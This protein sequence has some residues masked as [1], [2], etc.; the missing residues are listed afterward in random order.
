MYESKKENALKTLEKK[1]TKVDEINKVR[2]PPLHPTLSSSLVGPR[3]PRAQR[4]TGLSTSPESSTAPRGRHPSRAREAPQ[5]ARRVHEVDGGQRQAGAPEALLPRLRVQPQRRRARRGRGRYR[6]AAPAGAGNPS[7]PPRSP[8]PPQHCRFSSPNA[9]LFSRRAL[10]PS[11][12]APIS[13]QIKQL[14]KDVIELDSELRRVQSE[15]EEVRAEAEAQSGGVHRKA[16]EEA[17]GRLCPSVGGGTH[18]TPSKALRLALPRL[19]RCARVERGHGG[20]AREGSPF[21]NDADAFS[22]VFVRLSQVDELSKHIVQ[23]TAAWTNKR[24]AVQAEQESVQ[25]LQ[26][27]VKDVKGSIAKK[28]CARTS[29]TAQLCLLPNE[30]RSALLSPHLRH[31]PRAAQSQRPG[32]PSVPHAVRC[33]LR[34]GAFLTFPP[35]PPR[36]RRRRARLTSSRRTLR[37][38]APYW[39]S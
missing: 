39:R 1:Q 28:A 15:S 26:A 8:P 18:A 35:P 7:L 38:L 24:K 29:A 3:F 27:E 23:E 37:P 11:L 13:Q 33:P 36:P 32:L 17:R 25:R 19:T 16:Q 31:A 30:P 6:R 12:A 2:L 10:F 5:G 21:R 4:L 20:D 34:P 14:E 9:S 22:R